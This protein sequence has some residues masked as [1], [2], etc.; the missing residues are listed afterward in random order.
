[1][2]L[3]K[4]LEAIEI[5][6]GSTGQPQQRRVTI[7][8]R[9]DGYFTFAEEY[10]YRSEHEGEVI[11]EGWQR[12]PPEGIFESAEMAEAEGRAAALKRHEPR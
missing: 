2:K 5:A 11:A 10:F 9:D 8:Q 7:L 6:S 12:L 1:M 4:A 3:V